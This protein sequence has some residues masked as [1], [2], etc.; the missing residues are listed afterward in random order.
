MQK[1]SLL[2]LACL[3]ATQSAFSDGDEY[4]VY[5]ELFKTHVEYC[6]ATQI[7]SKK[8]GEGGPGGHAFLFIEGLCKDVSKNYPSVIPCSE[9]KNA[10]HTGVGISVDSDYENVNWV[11]VPDHELFMHGA[12][13][14][15]AAINAKAIDNVIAKAK[16]LR[17]FQGVLMKETAVPRDQSA[18]QYEAG[19]IE[20][21]IGTDL[22]M[23]Y[24][25]NLECVRMPFPPSKLKDIAT[26]L[27]DLNKRYYLGG[28]KYEWN[29][30]SNNCAHVSNKVFAILG[31]RE[32]IRSELPKYEQ[33]FNLAIPMN[34]L[35]TLQA[36]IH[37]GP[38]AFA[39][40]YLNERAR[41]TL[42]TLSWLPTQVGG[43]SSR[44][45][46]YHARNELYE[47]Q[48]LKAIT[49]IPKNLVQWGDN[50]DGY[51]AFFKPEFTQLKA[52]M[53]FWKLRYQTLLEDQGSSKRLSGFQ[54]KYQAYLKE[55]SELT[56]RLINSYNAVSTGS[57]W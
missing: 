43:I 21:A 52:N 5:R 27:N 49:I 7:K 36:V 51:E 26:Y 14:V 13:D 28:E 31:A 41:S 32:E 11:A 48:E 25:R 12:P 8:F 33:I 53:Q 38:I 2:A 39:D 15:N 50:L 44:Y 34:G 40:V 35:R 29:M 37:E 16:A 17:V 4:F 1:Y 18:D 20:Y 57:S 55:Q 10:D 54:S 22:A 24:G 3:L 19:V 6:G 42:E 45:A 47:T 9:L 30:V 46:A 23:R 56:T